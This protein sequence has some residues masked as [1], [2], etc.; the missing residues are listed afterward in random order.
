MK[1]VLGRIRHNV[2]RYPDAEAVVHPG[3][4]V[5][6]RQLWDLV[7]TTVAE[8]EANNVQR[9][10][11]CLPNTLDWLVADLAAASSG[12]AVVPIPQFFTS[13]Q[14]RH[15]IDDSC[16]D[17]V[18]SDHSFLEHDIRTSFVTPSACCEAR[19]YRVP[20]Q[21]CYS[22]SPFSKVTYTS[23]STG[24]P[25]GVCLGGD[26][27]DAV[28][29]AVA[30][31]LAPGALGRHLC[32]IPFATLLENVAGIYVALASGRSVVID[33][34]TRFGLRSNN[35]F[36]AQA[37]AGAVERSRAES[38]ILLP[39]M[40]KA[41]TER[42]DTAQLDSL[43]FVAVGGGKVSPDTLRQ[44]QLLGIPV[45]EGFGLSECGSVVCLNTPA[46]SRIGSVG[47]PLSH[48]DVRVDERGEVIVSGCAMQGYLN[49]AESPTEIATGDAGFFDEDGFLFITGRIKNM[50]V[51]SF[52]RNISP[53]WV[54]AHYLNQPC[55][56]RIAVYGEAK[57]YLSAV[58]W[59]DP[60]ITD[61]QLEAA[62]YSASK[63]LP[64]Y[65]RVRRWLRAD[66]PFSAADGTL[67]ENGK[68]CR[69]QI[70]TQYYQFLEALEGAA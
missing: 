64:D 16:V 45:Y 70:H 9:L 49:E 24:N 62:I 26:T 67:T 60:A 23:G 41:I 56:G 3:G 32:L 55:I 59:C 4:V 25:R 48:V 39:Q 36:D 21:Q 68:L 58:L 61:A 17:V 18:L 43:R 42:A 7:E 11:I 13:H 63:E 47:K 12:I 66:R 22:N 14:V 69:A 8:L 50:L 19:Y 38:V 29:D 15:L 34:V 35:Q 53:E 54:E 28:V 2:A 1:Q 51:S 27:L 37:F 57:P 40:L 33:D 10:A 6:Y 52:G 31:A 30:E 5:S 46:A 65:A 20:K 44:A